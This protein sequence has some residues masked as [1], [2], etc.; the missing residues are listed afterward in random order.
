[1]KREELLER[2]YDQLRRQAQVAMQQERRDHTLSATALV[3]EAYLRLGNTFGNEGHFYASAAEAMRRVLV[4]H[5]RAK[6]ALKRGGGGLEE[7]SGAGRRVELPEV[8]DLGSL[9]D[10][11]EILALDGALS[12]LKEE[13]GQAA[14]VVSM[15][16]FAGLDVTKTA[17]ALGISERTVKRDWQFARAFLYRCLAE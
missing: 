10:P 17:A 15:R 2:V 5:A 6:L 12:R 7:G 4:D 13:D 8:A 16:F 9:E 3:H 1:M 11:E 14:A